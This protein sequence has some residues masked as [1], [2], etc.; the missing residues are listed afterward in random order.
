[1]IST[2][3]Y[4]STAILVSPLSATALK[5]SQTLNQLKT[6]ETPTELR[7]GYIPVTELQRGD[8]IVNLGIIDQIYPHPSQNEVQIIFKPSRARNITSYFYSYNEKL[9]LA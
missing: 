5:L 9:K 6:M 4:V 3:A 7:S 8:T 1:M 2:T